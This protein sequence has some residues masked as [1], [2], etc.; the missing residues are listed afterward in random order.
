M[1]LHKPLK[2]QE[3]SSLAER[4]L[5]MEFD[6]IATDYLGLTKVQTLFPYLINMSIFI[7]SEAAV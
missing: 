7:H 5:P 2:D 3:L 6:T 4:L 1:E